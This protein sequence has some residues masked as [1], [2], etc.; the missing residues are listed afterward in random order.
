MDVIST[1][2]EMSAWTTARRAAG[3]SVGFV[4]TMGALHEGHLSLVRASQSA[5]EATV[6]SIFVNAAQFDDPD[7]WARYPRT[8]EDDLALCERAGVL[9]VFAPSPV[10]MWPPGSTTRVDPG[11]IAG[12]LEGAHRPGHF[13]GMATVVVKLLNIVDPDSAYFGAKDYQQVAVIRRVVDDLD[14]RHRIVACPTIREDD[15]LAMSSRNV[16]LGSDA[17]RSATVL[18]RSLT[19]AA[20]LHRSGCRDGRTLVDAAKNALASESAVLVDYVAL[21][22]PRTLDEYVDGDDDG[23]ILIAARVDGVRLIDNLVLSEWTGD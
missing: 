15:G 19:A 22:S 10:E 1:T 12:I 13:A 14:M 5:H 20:R 18:H 4:P 7:D 21:R 2:H 6:V 3:A 11:P 23:V 9:A 8:L 16:R 17:R